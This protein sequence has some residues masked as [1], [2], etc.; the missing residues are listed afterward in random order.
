MYI[1]LKISFGRRSRIVCALLLVIGLESKAQDAVELTLQEKKEIVAVVVQ[2]IWPTPSPSDSRKNV[3]TIVVD[4]DDSRE[5]ARHA[6]STYSRVQRFVPGSQRIMRAFC[7]YDQR[8]GLPA[9]WID[10]Q[11][12]RQIDGVSVEVDAVSA[13][14]V[15]SSSNA[16][17][18]LRKSGS[19][20]SIVDI[21]LTASPDGSLPAQAPV[22]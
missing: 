16:R 14:C 12:I 10:I 6:M 11:K 3:L 7:Y 8:T 15:T 9:M 18:T 5:L 21:H 22:Y 1:A 19:G 4:G 20:W 2:K 17:Y 13:V